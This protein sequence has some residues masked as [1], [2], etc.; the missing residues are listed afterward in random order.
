MKQQIINLVENQE[1]AI[2]NCSGVATVIRRL[3]KNLYLCSLRSKE[4]EVSRTNLSISWNGRSVDMKHNPRN[5]W[6]KHV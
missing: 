1:V 6:K 2:T 5:I 3:A 4:L